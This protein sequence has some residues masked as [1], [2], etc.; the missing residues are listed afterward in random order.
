M[1][2]NTVFPK[3]NGVVPGAGK[4][5]PF[6]GKKHLIYCIARAEHKGEKNLGA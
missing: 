5:A 1:V 2:T 6:C 4:R 3:Y